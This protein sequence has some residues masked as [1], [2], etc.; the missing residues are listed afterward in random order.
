MATVF[1]AR[2]QGPAGIGRLVALKVMSTALVNNER[3]RR[4]FLREA[5]IATRIEHPNVVRTY[6]VAEHDGEICI[7]MELVHGVR[8]SQLCSRAVPLSIA[9]RIVCDVAIGLH[10]AHELRDEN[11]A[12]LGIVHRDVSPQN[13]L[14]S[15]DGPSKLLDF[16]V[17]RVGDVTEITGSRFKPAYASPEQ[18]S[19][20]QVDRRSDVFSLGIILYEILTGERLFAADSPDEAIAAVLRAPIPDVRDARPDL[21]PA[22]AAVVRR[23][24]ERNRR[25]RY[26]T[27]KRLQQELVAAVTGSIVLAE[28]WAVGE[29][30]RR[31]RPPDFSRAQLEQAILSGQPMAA[32]D[33][34]VVFEL[35]TAPPDRS[36]PREL[37]PSVS[38]DAPTT[39][40]GVQEAESTNTIDV[41]AE[42]DTTEGRRY[43]PTAERRW[44][45]A[46]ASLLLG[47]AL[48][49][50]TLSR[51]LAYPHY[52]AAKHSFDARSEAPTAR[53]TVSS[54]VAG[55]VS[56]DDVPIGATPLRL[57]LLPT[58]FHTIAIVTAHAGHQRTTVTLAP[59]NCTRVHFVF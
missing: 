26:T 57:V 37:A 22:L 11:G 15:Y 3:Y 21:P 38:F 14:V 41:T 49:G 46:S 59:N 51:G 9:L 52:V 7:A 55:E 25:A 13:V 56:I 24:L 44:R 58:G 40:R 1:A 39:I 23:A 54:S 27:A 31:A 18:V 29:W 17:A 5:A 4:L 16:G 2:Q 35:P 10:A 33:G 47:G 50:A 36:A 19:G 43:M 45:W 8:L 53:V 42:I 28:D 20:E 32:F 34:S 12:P 30:L 6:D 48:A